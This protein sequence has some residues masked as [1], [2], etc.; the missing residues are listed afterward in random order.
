MPL[1][2]RGAE[3]AHECVDTL[4]KN[5]IPV[6]AEVDFRPNTRGKTENSINQ[7]DE[8]SRMKNIPAL[9]QDGVRVAITAKD[10]KG[11]PDLFWVTQ[12]FQRYGIAPEELVKTI[13]VNPA[14][15]FGVEDR[16]GSLAKGKDADILFFKKESG[17][18]LPALKKVMSQGQIVY[19]EK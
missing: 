11:L 10:E 8:K 3:E 1:I 18:P 4:K 9:I 14:S 17:H 2:I 19:E 13:T 5:N 16:I 15:I 6:I 7:K 12:Y